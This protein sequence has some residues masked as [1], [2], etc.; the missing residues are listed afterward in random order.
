MNSIVS[1]LIPFYNAEK[2]IEE[3]LISALNQT[4]KSI[5]IILVDDGSTDSG[6]S[7]VEKYLS[8]HVK[9]FKQ[10]NRGASAARN[11]A[12]EKSKGKFI[13][14]LD[15]DDILDRDKI[16]NQIR[17]Y[18]T[19]EK[20]ETIIVSSNFE[21]FTISI[22]SSFKAN[23]S[24]NFNNYKPI[25]WLIEA[26]YGKAMF[27][28]IVWLTPRKIIEKVGAWNKNLSYNDDS[29]FFARVLVEVDEIIHVKDANCFYRIGNNAS[30]GSQKNEKA[31]ISEFESL[32]L[33]KKLLLEKEN[34]ER[35]KKS[36]AYQ[37]SKINYSLYPN[38]PEIRKKIEQE[39]VDLK[40]NYPTNFGKGFFS[41]LGNIIGWKAAKRLKSLLK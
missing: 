32:N 13:Q 27:P 34:S 23:N 14:Y 21:Y 1:I 2:F 28:P 37:F 26:N 40:V 24:D 36:L 5:E 41:K 4:Y 8:D 15:A 6:V 10:E 17:I 22:S 12:F 30:I 18:E 39:L 29:E 7:I 33:I 20:K 19:Y 35:V 9:L 3:T 25:D 31:R 38:F 11:L 16:L